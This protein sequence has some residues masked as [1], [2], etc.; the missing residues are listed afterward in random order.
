MHSIW[1]L[2]GCDNKAKD[3]QNKALGFQCLRFQFWVQACCSTSEEGWGE[4]KNYL[5]FLTF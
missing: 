2:N 4:A 5:V 3:I 1:S